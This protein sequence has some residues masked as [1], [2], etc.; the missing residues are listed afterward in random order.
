MCTFGLS[1]DAIKDKGIAYDRIAYDFDLDDRAVV[2]DY[3]YGKLLLYLK[4]NKINPRNGR[5][6]GGTLIAP[7]AGEMAQELIMAVHQG[8]GA[9]A[10]FNKTYPYPVQ[11]R[12]HKMALVEEFSGSISN[13]LKKLMKMMYH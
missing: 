1:E 12:V 13:G 11:S 9:G 4:K 5:I 8:L 2:S 3:R 6:L 10:V 7:A